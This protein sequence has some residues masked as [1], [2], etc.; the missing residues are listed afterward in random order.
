MNAALYCE[1]LQSQ[2]SPTMERLGATILQQDGAP[3]HT[4]KATKNWLRAMNINVLDWLGQSLDLN[5]IENLWQ[6]MKRKIAQQQPSSISH[7]KAII[8]S[9]MSGRMELQLLIA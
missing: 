5:P 4:A 1:M 6:M 3:C 7:L 2:F 8:T 9:P